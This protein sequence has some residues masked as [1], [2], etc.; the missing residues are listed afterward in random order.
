MADRRGA[1]QDRSAENKEEEGAG[2]ITTPGRLVN[3]VGPLSPPTSL[4]TVNLCLRKKGN[5]VDHVEE[6]I[7]ISIAVVHNMW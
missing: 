1:S 7:L 4:M 6:I 5:C 2:A 3:P